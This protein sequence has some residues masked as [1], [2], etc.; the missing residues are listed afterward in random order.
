[1]SPFVLA[2]VLWPWPAAIQR[3]AP[4]A[5]AWLYVDDR[6]IAIRPCDDHTEQLDA[7]LTAT[8]AY[9]NAVGLTENQTKRQRWDQDSSQ[10]IE[11]RRGHE[12]GCVC[13]AEGRSLPTVLSTPAGP[14]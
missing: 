4:N 2:C 6:T 12:E 8:T 10:P 9:D 1:M 7:A 14:P 13:L 3:V 5:D 11:F